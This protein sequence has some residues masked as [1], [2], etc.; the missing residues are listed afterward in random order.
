MF[1]KLFCGFGDLRMEIYKK[2]FTVKEK[3]KIGRSKFHFCLRE[4][5]QKQLNEKVSGKSFLKKRC[6]GGCKQLLC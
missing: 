2:W 4:N 3:K 5:G 1:G 6:L